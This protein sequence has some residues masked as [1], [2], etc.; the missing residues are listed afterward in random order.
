M[1]PHD[2]R[3]LV[4]FRLGM[5]SVEAEELRATINRLQEELATKVAK[6]EAK[7]AN[8]VYPPSKPVNSYSRSNGKGKSA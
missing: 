3:H 2:P 6:K 7:K 1:N 4:A 5:I 8:G